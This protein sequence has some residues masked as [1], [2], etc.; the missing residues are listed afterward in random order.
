[1]SKLVDRLREGVAEFPVIIEHPSLLLTDAADRVEAL[2]QT[3]KKISE[4]IAYYL[5]I[6]AKK[7]DETIRMIAVADELQAALNRSKS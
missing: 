7:P 2:E 6:D 3:I 5:D 1:M 4:M